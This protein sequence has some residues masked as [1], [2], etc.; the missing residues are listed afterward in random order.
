MKYHQTFTVKSRFSF[1]VDMLRYDSCFP[2]TQS[3][4]SEITDSIM[5][6][7]GFEVDVARNVGRKNDQPTIARWESFSCQVSNIETRRL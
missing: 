3:D 4:A 5:Q 7:D 6:L 1:P 2:C